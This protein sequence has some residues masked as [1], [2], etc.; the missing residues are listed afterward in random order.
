MKKI[1]SCIVMLFSLISY[2]QSSQEK[3]PVFENCK[4]QPEDDTCF[5]ATIQ[6]NFKQ[7][8]NKEYTAEKSTIIALFAVDTLGKFEVLFIDAASEE[9][10]NETKRVFSLLPIVQPATY[11]GK[12]IYAKYTLKV[13]FPFSDDIRNTKTAEDAYQ[14]EKITSKTEI[15]EFD[16]IVYRKFE[17]PQFKSGLNIPFNHQKYA[18]FEAY[19]NQVGA[20]SHTAEKPY[21]YKD[22]SRYYDFQKQYQAKGKNK[23]SW[24]GRK[25]WNENLVEVQGD[26]YWFLFNPILDVRGGKDFNSELKNTF[27]NTR[28]VNIQ[29]GLG[30]NITFTTSIYESQGR[31]A[32]YYNAYAVSLKPSGGN[33]GTIPGVGIAKLFKTDA[34][35]FPMAEANIKFTANQFFDVQLGYGRNFIGDGYRSI[36]QGDAT[37]PYPFIKFN[38]TFWKIKYTNTYMFLRDITP[39][40]T[41]EDTYASKYMANHYL[42]W[43]VTKR[44]NLGLFESVVWSNTNGRGFDPNFINP[45]IF[46]RAVEFASSPK[47]GNAL[48]GLTSK[49]KFN[50]QISAYGQ[51]LIDEFSVGDVSKGNKSW[52]NKFGYQIG[53]KYFNAFNIENLTLQAEY[54]I[55]RPY[56]YSHSNTL[57]NYTHNNQSMGHAWGAN[58]KEL[59][60]IARYN[61]NRYF[62]QAKLIYGKRGFDFTDGTNNFNYGTNLFIP[63]DSTTNPR[64]YDEGAFAGQG[65][66][67][68]ILIGDFT[69]GYII[70]P[71]SNLKVFANVIH[72]SFDPTKTSATFEKS[73]TTW[74]SVGISTDLFNWYFDY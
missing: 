43:N 73:N 71:N 45:I 24:W 26:G 44:W 29:A 6:D 3:L 42:S 48:L 39:E 63:Y 37:S 72:R 2:S 35:D 70:N 64:P 36:I 30:K 12:P 52:K 67:T 50:S 9:I 27:V 10:K 28:G 34:F 14:T 25:F 41:A 13:N 21:S 16:K 59:I 61:K 1:I 8:F 31:F 62:A 19:M 69:A 5:F 22:V 65:N 18:E 7:N 23:T 68:T 15:E 11:N 33:P 49:Y 58:F 66:T 17:N 51:F 74:V 60:G 4:A 40:N 38:T 56:V 47:S 55:V 53:A 32:D 46:Y 57:T 54:N 20:N